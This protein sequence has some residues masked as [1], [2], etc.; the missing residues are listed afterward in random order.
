MR[1][2]I[3]V[4]GVDFDSAW[5][6]TKKTC[7]YTNHTVL[8]EALERWPV[9]MLENMLPRHL[10]IIYLIN[11]RHLA[12]VA[13]DGFQNGALFFDWIEYFLRVL[14]GQNLKTV[15]KAFPNDSGKLR[16]MSLIEEDG[17]KRVN[18]AYLAIVGSHAVNGVAAIHSQIIKDDTFRNFYQM[19]VNLGQENKWQNKVRENPT[20]PKPLPN[21]TKCVTQP[22]N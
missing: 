22:K 17:E 13:K 15:L 1:L 14:I 7:A 11:A 19:S 3:D 10:Q 9:K 21:L 16:E 2:L 18:M 4:E 20:Q 8:P 5:E 6:V 12:D